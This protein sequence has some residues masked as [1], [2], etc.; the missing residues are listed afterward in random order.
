MEF[1]FIHT[2]QHTK[3]SPIPGIA[4]QNVEVTQIISS[5]EDVKPHV[6]LGDSVVAK[7]VLTINALKISSIWREFFLTIPDIC[8]SKHVR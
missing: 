2:F 1:H 8:V 4:G 5:L 6:V 7:M 3:L